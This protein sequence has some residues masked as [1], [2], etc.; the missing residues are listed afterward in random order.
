MTSLEHQIQDLVGI[1]I[2]LLARMGIN[3]IDISPEELTLMG[4]H[5]PD[6]SLVIEIEKGHIKVAMKKDA[7]VEAELPPEN[8]MQH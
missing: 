4:E 3:K 1:V 8:V 7:E 2:V 6:M 5:Y